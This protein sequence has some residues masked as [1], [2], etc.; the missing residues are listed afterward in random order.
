MLKTRAQIENEIQDIQEW[1]TFHDPNY[2][3]ENFFCDGEISPEEAT[4]RWQEKQNQLEALQDELAGLE[5]G[6]R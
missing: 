3:P 2:A 6:W 1:M 4:A 5:L